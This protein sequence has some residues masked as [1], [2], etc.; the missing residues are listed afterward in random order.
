MSP[1]PHHHKCRCCKE[2]F[3]PSKRHPR[4]RFCAKPDCRKASKQHS[5]KQWLLR[6]P[7]YFCG[8]EHVE[9]VRDWRKAHPGYSRGKRRQP[10]RKK[11]LAALQD[12]VHAQPPQQKPVAPKEEEPSSD[13]PQRQDTA[14]AAD[15]CRGQALQDLVLLQ[16]PLVVGLLSVMAG[17][18]L[19][20][21]LLPFARRLVE[22]GQRVLGPATNGAGRPHAYE[23]TNST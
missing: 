2:F 10:N 22:R 7:G 1:S 21:T 14:G 16:V 13:F 23:T 9:R 19:Q 11:G 12:F 17:E 15:S 3:G 4:Q 6:H 5:Q 18:A 8:L 20:E